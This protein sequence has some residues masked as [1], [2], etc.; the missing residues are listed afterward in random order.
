M[1]EIKIFTNLDKGFNEKNCLPIK[2]LLK[3]FN[4]KM[5]NSF[6]NSKIIIDF[7]K[8]KSDNY[9]NLKNKVFLIIGGDNLFFKKNLFSYFESFLHKI[10]GKNKYKIID[11]F[12]AI[13]PKKISQFP[14]GS[15]FSEYDKIIKDVRIG[16]KKNV[17]FILTNSIKGKN[18]ISIPLFIQ[19][20]FDKIKKLVNKKIPSEKE[21]KNK[22]FCVFVVSSNSSRERVDF[23]RML[24][25]Y[26]KVDSY[27]KVMNNMGEKEFENDWPTNSELFKKYKFVICFENSFAEDYITEKLLNAMFANSIPIYRGAP[28]VKKYFNTKSFINFDDY[29]SYDKMIKKIIELDNDDNKYKEFFKKPWFKNNMVP[30]KIKNTETE[31]IKFY[32]KRLK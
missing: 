16:K 19:V 18:F 23:F 12:D 6:E 32:R 10:I 28:N 13:I 5:V 8:R 24:S 7:I 21:I 31:L 30:D 1:K 22:K 17:F 4:G 14:T 25:R 15:F 11:F 27:G 26:K 20:Y 3:R 9:F 29:G 2:V